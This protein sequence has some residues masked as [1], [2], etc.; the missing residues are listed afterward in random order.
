MEEGRGEPNL[1]GQMAGT[2]A[3]I[4][5]LVKTLPPATRRRLLHH[6]QVEFESLLAAMSDAGV[7]QVRAERESAEWM[8][9][10]FL[11]RIAQADLKP[12]RRRIRKAPEGSAPDKDSDARRQPAST[13]IDFEL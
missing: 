8:R 3:M 4:S 7:S 6:T 1:L 13:N 5:A 9:D 2:I 11:R 12:S 10:L